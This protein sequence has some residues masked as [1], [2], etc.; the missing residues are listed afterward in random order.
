LLVWLI[1]KEDKILFK[2]TVSL[3]WQLLTGLLNQATVSASLLGEIV[4][5][6][7]AY[8]MGMV[9][10]LVGADVLLE[11]AIENA[12]QT[13]DDCLPQYAFTKRACQP[14]LCA[15]SPSPPTNSTQNCPP[16]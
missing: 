9:H 5:P 12:E 10:E 8:T 13:P 6:T 11:R 14:P 16:K 1:T 2:A 3:L 4:N 15:P 7:Q